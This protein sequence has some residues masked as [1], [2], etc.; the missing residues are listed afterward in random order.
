M[1]A[2]LD[3][4]DFKF[5]NGLVYSRVRPLIR[6]D[7]P[8]A[9]LPP[10]PLLKIAI[11]LH[12]EMRRRSVTAARMLEERPWRAVL[13]EWSEPGGLRDQYER[14]NLALQDIDLGS[15]TDDDLLAQ[16]ECLAEHFPQVEG[17]HYAGHHPGS[18]AEAIAHLNALW[19][20]GDLV[21]E[22]GAD[23]VYRFRA[24]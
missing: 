3:A 7:K 18:D 1:L 13:Q 12:P 15:S 10:L 2:P 14:A 17:G 23:G 8:A 24:A 4:L 21:R 9:K 6:P 22:F 5:V 16:Q 20:Q 19:L 11:R